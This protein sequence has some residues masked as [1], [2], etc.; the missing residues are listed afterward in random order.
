MV[1]QEEV[2]HG[3][4]QIWCAI[5]A[6]D[7]Q[8]TLWHIANEREAMAWWWPPCEDSCAPVEDE[9]AVAHPSQ[10]WPC[11]RSDTLLAPYGACLPAVA[12]LGKGRRMERQRTQP[13]RQ[14]GERKQTRTPEGRAVR[15]IP[16]G[17]V[18][19]VGKNATVVEYGGDIVLVDG[20]LGRSERKVG[21]ST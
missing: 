18:G 16:L 9:S 20:V 1:S 21:I 5:P 17:G 19:E 13:R 6:V 4:P 12:Q 11:T 8:E 2:Y 14:A 7:T 10:T 3:S 15:I